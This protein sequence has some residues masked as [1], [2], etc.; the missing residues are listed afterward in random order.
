MKAPTWLV[1]PIAALLLASAPAIGSEESGTTTG[2]LCV[3]FAPDLTL[4]YTDQDCEIEWYERRT[5]DDNG[6]RVT[7]IWEDGVRTEFTSLWDDVTQEEGV[8]CF[9]A[10]Q[11]AT[12]GNTAYGANWLDGLCAVLSREPSGSSWL[13]CAT[14]LGRN[15]GVCWREP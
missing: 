5:H 6:E 8:A 11:A 1:T 9:Q 14:V 2:A 12:N 3:A 4:T 7:L 10:V 13:K 15:N